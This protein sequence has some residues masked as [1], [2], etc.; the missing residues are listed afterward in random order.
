MIYLIQAG[1]SAVKIGYTSSIIGRYKIMQTDNYEELIILNL[2]EGDLKLEGEIHYVARHYRIRNEW[3]KKEV[4]QNKTVMQMVNKA[5]KIGLEFLSVA[6]YR[7]Y[8]RKL[9]QAFIR[10]LRE[11]KGWSQAE[12]GLQIGVSEHMVNSWENGSKIAFKYQEI[13]RSVLDY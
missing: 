10:E 8:G 4:L 3:Y 9:K 12:L 11:S 1:K 7:Q 13:V 2:I 5:T 6:F